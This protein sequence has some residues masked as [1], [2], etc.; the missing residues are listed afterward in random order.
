MKEVFYL[1]TEHIQDGELTDLLQYLTV[2]KGKGKVIP[3]HHCVETRQVSGDW[4][5]MAVM[6]NTSLQIDLYRYEH[7]SGMMKEGYKSHS[8]FDKYEFFSE[9]AEGKYKWC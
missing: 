2:L 6:E 5:L 9:L 8:A 1:Q 7:L 4:L 3:N